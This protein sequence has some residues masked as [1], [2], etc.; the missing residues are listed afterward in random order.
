VLGSFLCDL[1]RGG[2]IP[3][4]EQGGTGRRREAA[5]G[6]RRNGRDSRFVAMRF[7]HKD[8]TNGDEG[9]HHKDHE[10]KDLSSR[11]FLQSNFARGGGHKREVLGGVGL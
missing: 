6:L 9:S 5:D 3:S 2:R 1:F 11:G 7:D 4:I 8:K 10:K